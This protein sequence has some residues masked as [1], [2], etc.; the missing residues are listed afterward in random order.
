MC[1][2]THTEQQLLAALI[3]LAADEKR[4]QE[5]LVGLISQLSST[6]LAARAASLRELFGKQ[7]AQL[8]RKLQAVSAV[9][10]R[11]PAAKSTPSISPEQPRQQ[12]QRRSERQRGSR[13]WAP[14]HST[15]VAG[16]WTRFTVKLV[17]AAI[18]RAEAAASALGL[19]PSL[20]EADAVTTLR[21]SAA[22]WPLLASDVIAEDVTTAE[23]DG[24][25][26]LRASRY[27]PDG[28]VPDAVR[29]RRLRRLATHFARYQRAAPNPAAAFFA[30]YIVRAVT[31][32]LSAGTRPCS[33]GPD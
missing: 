2:A 18:A 8:Q 21:H 16:R 15:V 27:G 25:A 11:R 3:T 19:R 9:D 31:V 33:L 14:P 29:D 4:A 30:H 32:A 22:P 24:V 20:H 10:G 28:C 17:A 23:Q 6:Q 13:P 12:L 5:K 1:H 7:R 26:A